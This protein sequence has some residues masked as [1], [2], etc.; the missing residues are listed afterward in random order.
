MSKLSSSKS[1]K[2]YESLSNVVKK[3]LRTD[4]KDINFKSE[5]Q[6]Q[7]FLEVREFAS[8]SYGQ[9]YFDNYDL[10]GR[11]I[12]SPSW[13][14]KADILKRAADI[15]LDT[16]KEACEFVQGARA[17]LESVNWDD[18][19]PSR[20]AIE[21]LESDLRHTESKELNSIYLLLQDLPLKIF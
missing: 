8:K 11:F 10:I 15:I 19:N 18:E 3:L 17:H 4:P 9:L 6:R 5:E 14:G 1:D 20:K 12:P 16:I 2:E 7:I 13:Y 21:N